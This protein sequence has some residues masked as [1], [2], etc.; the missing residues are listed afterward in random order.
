[1]IHSSVINA[2]FFGSSSSHLPDKIHHKL[3]GWWSQTRCAMKSIHKSKLWTRMLWCASNVTLST[4]YR[5][6]DF[7][8]IS[9]PSNTRQSYHNNTP[10]RAQTGLLQSECLSWTFVSKWYFENIT[11]YSRILQTLQYNTFVIQPLS[12]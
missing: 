6:L 12:K 7:Q 2:H 1:M 3:N 9:N 5:S 4:S 10:P 11:K 8:G